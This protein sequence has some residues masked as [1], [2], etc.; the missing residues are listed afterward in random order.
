[1][2]YLIARS[3]G[4]QVCGSF[5]R[6]MYLFADHQLGFAMGLSA[7][8]HQFHHPQ[9]DYAIGFDCQHHQGIDHPPPR[10]SCLPR[11]K[12]GNGSGLKPD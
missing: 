6:R 9:R 12:R 2:D 3:T 5:E 1:M 8:A 11:R 4:H 10:H 7:A